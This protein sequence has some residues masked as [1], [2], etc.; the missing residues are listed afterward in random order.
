MPDRPAG[1]DTLLCHVGNDPFAHHGIVNPPVFH[2]STVLYPTVAALEHSLRDRFAQVS[3][4]RYGTPTTFAFEEAVAA[5]EGGE[6]AMAL[7]SGLAAITVALTTFLKAGDHLLMTDSVYAPVRSFCQGFLARFGVEI[8]YYDPLIGAGIADL[9]R[10]ETRIVYLESP[11]S[12]T[13]EVQDVPAIAAA[14]H[15]AGALVAID[16]T[17]ATPLFLKPLSLGADI[18][19]HAA[20]KYLVGHSDAMLGVLVA[21]A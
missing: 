18:V 4:G 15:R 20:T 3:Y 7:P 17:W 21:S 8:T 16:N 13:F 1:E 2:A 10:P 19:I 12:L 6:R 14:A 5:L 11:G 9:I